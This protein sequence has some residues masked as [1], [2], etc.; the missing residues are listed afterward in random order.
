[1]MIGAAIILIL[2]LRCHWQNGVDLPSVVG[3]RKIP[4]T[5]VSKLVMAGAGGGR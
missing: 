4:S 1:M 5:G 3:C 2:D